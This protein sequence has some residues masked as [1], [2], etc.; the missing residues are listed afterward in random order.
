MA[1]KQKFKFVIP[2]SFMSG[3]FKIQVY[4]DENM[5][6]GD[7]P[8]VGLNCLGSQE[9]YIQSPI[10]DQVS[11]G[12]SRQTFLHEL[13]HQVFWQL[14]RTELCHDEVLVDS[15]SHALFQF[16][17]TASGDLLGCYEKDKAKAKAK[18][19][20]AKKNGEIK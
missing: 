19:K 2:T 8:E 7:K 5:A 16:I 20:K 15:M 10:D 14:G 9:I 17:E 12:V 4:Y 1:K 3:A 13:V 18:A 6:L 11:G